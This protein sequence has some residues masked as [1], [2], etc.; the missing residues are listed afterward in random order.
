[1]KRPS[2]RTA[3]TSKPSAPHFDPRTLT[4]EERQRAHENALTLLREAKE[5]LGTPPPRT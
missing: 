4:L 5:R 1:M 3:K 2:K